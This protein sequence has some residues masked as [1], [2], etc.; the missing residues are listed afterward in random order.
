MVGNKGGTGVEEEISGSLEVAT[1]VV[2]NF[3]GVAV[4]DGTEGALVCA[5][6]ESN[7]RC[8]ISFCAS[9][10]ANNGLIGVLG[11]LSTVEDNGV[12][13]VVTE[14]FETIRLRFAVS[15]LCIVDDVGNRRESISF[16]LLVSICV[17]PITN[18]LGGTILGIVGFVTLGFTKEPGIGSEEKVDNGE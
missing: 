15:E 2:L 16:V 6:I 10:A 8:I 3:V 17:V 12:E 7:R 4:A 14:L 1:A 5:S 9:T 13:G 18:G 11:L